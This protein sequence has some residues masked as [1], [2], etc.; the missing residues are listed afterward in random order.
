MISHA[1]L[2]AGFCWTA[3]LN[4]VTRSSSVH[5]KLCYFWEVSGGQHLDLGGPFPAHT[6]V[7]LHGLNSFL[8]LQACFGWGNGPPNN[9]FGLPRL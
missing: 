9:Q 2:S 5:W 1:V 7:V 6:K 4:D 8:N 3:D